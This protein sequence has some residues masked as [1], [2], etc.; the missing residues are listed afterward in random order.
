[1]KKL[2][3][4][5]STILLFA[6]CG[7]QNAAVFKEVSSEVMSEIDQEYKLDIEQFPLIDAED[8]ENA[9]A[10]EDLTQKDLATADIKQTQ[11]IIAKNFGNGFRKTFQIAEDAELSDED[12]QNIR[13][14]LYFQLFQTFVYVDENGQEHL[15]M[16]TS[17]EKEYAQIS[18]ESEE[19]KTESIREYVESLDREAFIDLLLDASTR[20]LN[21]TEEE[22]KTYRETLE[23]LT[24]EQ[25]AE[26]REDLIAKLSE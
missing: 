24:D 7:C 21:L 4:V 10:L 19:E 3:I 1:M 6:L 22:Q 18:A 17:A 11:A 23:Q 14:L 20:D 25:L 15:M 26:L 16:D 8:V 13:G 2:V 9:P 5:V 12:W